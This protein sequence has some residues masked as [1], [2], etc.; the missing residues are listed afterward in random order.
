MVSVDLY[1]EKNV[2]ELEAVDAH[3]IELEKKLEVLSAEQSDMENIL[4]ANGD[5]FEV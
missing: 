1:L 4:N 2:Q 5:I 3:K